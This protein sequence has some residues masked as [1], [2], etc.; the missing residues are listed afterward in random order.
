M[1]L[2]IDDVERGLFAKYQCAEDPNKV[3]HAIEGLKEGEFGSVANFLKNFNKIRDEL[4]K[5]L[6][7]EHLPTMMMKDNFV[8]GL[9]TTLR[10][11]VELKKPTTF[12][13]ALEVA[14]RKASEDDPNGD[15]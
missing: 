1:V 11:K 9:K 8:T 3:W 12:D 13:E 2:T 7:S 15:G 5:A 4:C 10:W 14:K 6:E